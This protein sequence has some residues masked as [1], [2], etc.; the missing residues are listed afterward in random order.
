MTTIIN[1]SSP[2]I[3]FSDGSAQTSATRPFLNRI[4]NGGMT[5]DQRNAG[6]AVTAEGYLVDRWRVWRNQTY[7]IQQS[8][9]APSGFSNSLLVTKTSTT[10][11]TFAYLIQYIEGF[12][13]AD[14]SFG[15]A[16][17]KT[18]TLSFWVKSSVTGTFSAG[19]NNSASN[20]TFPATYT[21]SSANT[22]EQKSVTIAGDTSGTWV[23]STNGNGAGVWFNFGASGSGTANAWN[24]ADVTSGVTGN[25]NLGTTN[26]ATFQI[27]GVQLEKGSTATSF[28]YRPYGTELAL[29]QRYAVMITGTEGDGSY[30][31]FMSGQ[32]I[33][34]TLSEG[35]VFLPVKMRTYPSLTT[36]STAS[37]YSVYASGSGTNCS[38]VPILNS[39][40]NSPLIACVKTTVASGLTTG[41]AMSLTANGTAAAYLLYTAEL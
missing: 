3:T 22:W 31:R 10:Q 32:N 13:F 6:A 36:S 35:S 41:Q 26:G 40:G 16:N 30:I 20:R 34:T 27:T 25:A 5:I 29:C 38:S 9:D 37:N 39:Q 14:M 4:I 18:V 2:S 15:T 11:S 24:A 12:N 19:I 33:S 21:I 8:T 17:A 23:G 7:T 28:D 1:G